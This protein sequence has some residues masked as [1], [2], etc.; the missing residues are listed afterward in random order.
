M[1]LVVSGDEFRSWADH[2]VMLVRT[3]HH[4]ETPLGQLGQSAALGMA[5][6]VADRAVHPDA[7]GFPNRPRIGNEGDQP[8]ITTTLGTRQRKLLAMP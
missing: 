7:S 8:D 4:P 1:A 5:I 6:R 3:L 2:P